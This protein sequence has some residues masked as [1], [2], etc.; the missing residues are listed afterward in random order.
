MK[1]GVLTFHRAHNC[2]AA[3]QCVALVLAITKLGHNVN[4]LNV[5]DEG[6]APLVP[7]FGSFRA[8][9]GWLRSL[10]VNLAAAERLWFR[11]RR[12]QRRNMILTAR[13][14]ATERFPREF[15]RI[16]LGSDQVLSPVLGT[17][18]LELYLM[19][20][21]CPN[22]KK[23]AYASSF[24]VKSL[25]FELRQF[26]AKGLSRF[27]AIGVRE[28]SG[29]NICRVELG[30]KSRIDMVADPTL[31]LDSE[32]YYMLESPMKI[33]ENFLLV[34]Y[35]GSARNYV[36]NLAHKIAAKRGLKVV[37]ASVM[38]GKGSGEQWYATDPGEFLWLVRHA[39][40]VVTTSFH[41]T[42]FSIIN[43]KPFVSIIPL[44]SKVA[45]RVINLLD[46][47]G[48]S[49]QIVMENAN[50]EDAVLKSGMQYDD[51][52]ERRL[53]DFRSESMAFLLEI[54]PLDK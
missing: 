27:N 16:I 7:H 20:G 24:G 15:D 8:F 40:C 36:I 49:R 46:R 18:A 37:V 44:G 53:R 54:A 45:D 23:Y 32:D 3:L 26:Y 21:R 17:N 48:L 43:R 2:G 9:L 29:V 1:I 22:I 13:I 28:Y 34:Y 5:D 6:E 42:V 12:F 31:L 51:E 14:K 50:I 39:A 47:L 4:V 38:G 10:V 41:G 30:L 52:F 33:K 11:Y 35:I 25:P 19:R